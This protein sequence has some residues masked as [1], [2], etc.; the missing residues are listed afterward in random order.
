MVLSSMIWFGLFR[1]LFCGESSLRWFD[2]LLQLNVEIIGRVATYFYTQRD[3]CLWV[4]A[5]NKV[6]TFYL[7]SKSAISR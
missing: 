6:Y 7:K 2:G 5:A 4:E 1:Q 3:G